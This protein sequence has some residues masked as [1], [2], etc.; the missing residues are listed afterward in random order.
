MKILC[1]SNDGQFSAFFNREKDIYIF[2]GCSNGNNKDNYCP[3]HYDIGI[4]CD[5]GGCSNLRPI[6]AMLCDN[7]H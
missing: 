5:R 7:C 1:K 3:D 6:G 4:F 2:P